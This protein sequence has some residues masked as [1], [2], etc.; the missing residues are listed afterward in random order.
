MT[1]SL[2]AIT[3]LCNLAWRKFL[4][5]KT[6]SYLSIF[7]IILSTVVILIILISTSGVD[8][9]IRDL[10]KD[11]LKNKNLAS[12]QYFLNEDQGKFDSIIN[13][14][15]KEKKT[16]KARDKNVTNVDYGLA[17]PVRLLIDGYENKTEDENTPLNQVN[18]FSINT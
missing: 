4:Y 16:E 2:N 1:S 15:E 17:S 3:N 13:K 6:S 9:F 8:N 11:S 10:S 5:S 18:S 12:Y 7:T 14:I